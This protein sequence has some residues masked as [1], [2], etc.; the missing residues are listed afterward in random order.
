M[1]GSWAGTEP[2]AAACTAGKDPPRVKTPLSPL[3]ACWSRKQTQT[4]CMSEPTCAGL[5][6][7]LEQ[8]P[9][10]IFW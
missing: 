7:S 2:V 8:R 1:V 3:P 4:R 9:G 6:F 5:G 10:L